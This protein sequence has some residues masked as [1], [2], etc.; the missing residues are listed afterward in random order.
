M[1]T[2]AV[3]GG[4]IGLLAIG[5]CEAQWW[6]DAELPVDGANYLTLATDSASQTLF[7][8]GNLVDEFGTPEQAMHYCTYSD[9]IWNTS[10]PFDGQVL[11]SIVF[12]DTLYVGG[13]FTTIDGD[14]IAHI[15]RRVNGQWLP[16]GAFDNAV[17]RLKVMGG[18]LYAIGDF[19]YADGQPCQGIAKHSDIGWQSIVPLG[20][21]NCLLKDAIYYDNELVVS[22]TITFPGEEYRHII[23]LSNGVW[24]PLGEQGIF[25]DLSAGGQLAIYQGHLF[26]AGLIDI[27]AGN[28]GHAIM[29]WNGSEWS[30]VGTGVQ[31][32]NGGYDQLI[33]VDD[34]EVHDELLYACGGFSYA[35]NIPANRIATWNGSEWCSVGGSFGDWAVN[36][37]AFL[38]DTMFAACW[39]TADGQPVNHLAKFIAPTYE[40][41]CSVP[42]TVDGTGRVHLELETLGDAGY[43]LR[44]HSGSSTGYVV[45]ATGRCTAVLNIHGELPFTLPARTPGSYVLHIPGSGSHK[46]ILQP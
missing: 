18:E 11:T 34:L 20:C 17:Y 39:D 15:A 3:I 43:R 35:G 42:M 32:E 6:A 25:G 31:D 19:T 27:N 37:I 23:H 41:N 22:G 36:S 1:R 33:R 40:G 30:A 12:L 7:A 16:A 38:N 13:A 14:P 29:R 5:S 2:I 26:V 46:L 4:G 8:M 24:E 44:G 21:D 10:V 9:G 28:A 45:D